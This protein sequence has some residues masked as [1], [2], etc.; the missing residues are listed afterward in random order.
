MKIRLQA[1]A[2]VLPA[3]LFL[4][5]LFSA[6]SAHGLTIQEEQELAE[7]FLRTVRQRYSII[8]DPAISDYIQELG[9]KIVS[10]LPQQPFDYH[11]YVIKQDAY[12]AFAGPAGHIFVYS[13]LF[14]AL[15]HEG[16][17][18]ALLAHEIAHASS[19]H[20]SKMIESSKK[21]S[22]GTL[23]GVI[24]GILIGLG[25]DSSIGSAVVMGSMAAGESAVLSYTREKEMQADQLGREYL[26]KAGYD[27]HSMLSLL[28]T[29]RSQE[30][31]T[32]D[33]IPT[34]L[35]THPATADRLTYLSSRL[36][37][38]AAPNP[39]PSHAFER[40]HTRL[41]ALYGDPSQALEHFSQR[42]AENPGQPMAHYGY[43]LA[44]ERNGNPEA[45]LSEFSLAYEDRPD[46]PYLSAD[47]GRVNF[48][49]GNYE[50][51][52]ML[53]EK[54]VDLGG[55]GPEARLYLGR[56][57]LGLGDTVQA[58]KTLN[59]LVTDHPEFTPGHYFLGKSYSEKGDPANAHYHL[60]LY[61]RGRND[62]EAAVHHLRRALETMKDPEKVEKIK[63]LLEKDK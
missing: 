27:L 32:T 45:A 51:A 63:S 50:R 43:G 6:G 37:G 42:A 14:E 57:Y 62:Q 4:F 17:L 10:E 41:S 34:Y 2:L 30:W 28:K 58:S 48:L 44:L 24:A 55:A 21:A 7:E 38:T 3:L 16:E 5:F 1:T 46:D 36:S 53:L 25:G 61:H 23:A 12:N 33:Q 31:F 19:R 26:T 8:K 18:A 40:A 47:L 52:R 49:V 60:G 11:F 22:L 39:K 35:R 20:I 15:S 56:T 29:I 54:S 59:R 13:G 9:E